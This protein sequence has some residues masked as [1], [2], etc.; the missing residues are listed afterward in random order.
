MYLV[1]LYLYFTFS[2]VFVEVPEGVIV[3]FVGVA[4]VGSVRVEVVLTP[5]GL[6]TETDIK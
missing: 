6:V 2:A 1:L 5:Y 4:F 3:L